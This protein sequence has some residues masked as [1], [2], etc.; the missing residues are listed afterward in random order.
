MA[1]KPR[2]ITPENLRK[3]IAHL[4]GL[5][6]VEPAIIPTK[7]AIEENRAAFRAAM[8]KGHTIEQLVDIY[9]EYGSTLKPDT[10][11]GHLRDSV[12]S[13]KTRKKGQSGKA[14]RASTKKTASREVNGSEIAA[15][16]AMLVEGAAPD[17]DHNA[18]EATG[19]QTTDAFHIQKAPATHT[20][21]DEDAYVDEILL[22]LNAGKA[23]G[24][25]DG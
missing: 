15:M 10:F 2:G 8:N 17:K 20:A 23:A 3:L 11:A 24:S 13:T 7:I 16:N 21:E 22:Q 1:K 12:I 5:P 9:N 18:D 6:V 25:D 14:N 19:P 4:E